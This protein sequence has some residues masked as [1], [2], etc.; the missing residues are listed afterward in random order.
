[1]YFNITV[2]NIIPQTLDRVVSH[3]LLLVNYE[4][5]RIFRYAKKQIYICLKICIMNSVPALGGSIYKIPRL[6]EMSC[7]Q[8]WALPFISDWD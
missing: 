3:K 7:S 2:Q 6:S 5:K 8:S 4:V 1:M